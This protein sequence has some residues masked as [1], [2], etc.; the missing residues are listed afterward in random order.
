MA[1][2]QEWQQ[3]YNA[4]KAHTD[5]TIEELR[6]EVED[7]KRR[8]DEMHIRNVSYPIYYIFFFIFIYLHVAIFGNSCLPF[9]FTTTEGVTG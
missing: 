8:F 7:W 6:K 4:L 3:K 1:V 9:W 2:E 5:K